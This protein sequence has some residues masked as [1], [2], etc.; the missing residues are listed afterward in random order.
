MA[1]NVT[2]NQL[3]ILFDLLGLINWFAVHPTSM[4]NTNILISGDNKGVASL[5]ME[6]HMN[7][8][9]TSSKDSFVA[10]FASTNLGDV[11]PN[12]N[13]PHCMY[14]GEPCSNNRS[15]CED[16]TEDWCVATGPGKDMWES[17]K[18][19]GDKQFRKSL[20]LLNY[21]IKNQTP[22]A[23]EFKSAFQWIDMASQEVKLEN[24]EIVKTCKP[25]LGYSFAAGTTDG[26][27]AFDFRQGTMNGTKGWNMV[28]DMLKAPSKEQQECHYPKPILL[29]TGEMSFPYQ[30]HPD[31]VDTQIIGLGSFWIAAVPGEFTTMAGRRLRE[32]IENVA[33]RRNKNT[34]VV[35]GGLSNIYT[36]Y[37]TT[38]EEYQ[39]QR[40]EAASTIY[41][42][43]TLNAY[44]QQYKKLAEKLITND[45]VLSD[46]SIH[47]PDLYETVKGYNNFFGFDDVN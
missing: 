45:K 6:K 43:Y 32:T 17:K 39:K 25:A 13:T 29:N 34:K 40:Y 36:H 46:E 24:G 5:M 19:I 1:S 15:T 38:P 12:T 35:I 41:G 44:Q 31:I 22:I 11:S 14:S 8:G 27:G 33:T 23:G 28:R 2:I 26:P 30:W 21:P 7:M 37:I 10:A 20:D 47:P 9:K 4:N 42:P 3:C 18:L 16:E